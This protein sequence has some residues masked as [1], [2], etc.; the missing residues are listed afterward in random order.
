MSVLFMTELF[1]SSVAFL[2]TSVREGRSVLMIGLL[3]CELREQGTSFL[4]L[5]WLYCSSSLNEVEKIAPA[6]PPKMSCNH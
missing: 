1:D 6:L 2:V 4:G 3:L 5:L